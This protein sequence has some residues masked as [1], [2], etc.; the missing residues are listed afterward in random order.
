MKKFYFLKI[1][2]V[3]LAAICCFEA[4]AKWEMLYQLRSPYCMHIAP[5]G[6]MLVA[7]YLFD[8]T[9]GIYLSEDGGAT[10]TKT[11]APDYTYGKF[12]DAG[13]YVIATGGKGRIARSKD[14]G[15]TWEITNYGS[16]ISD[17]LSADVIE[18]TIC[19]AAAYHNERLYIGDFNGGGILYSEDF[20]ETWVRTNLESLQYEADGGGKGDKP[21]KPTKLT[22]NIYNLVSYK[23]ELYAFGVYFVFKY[24]EANDLWITLRND[25]NFMSNSTIHNDLLVCGRSVANQSTDIEFL[26]SF[27]GTQWGEIERPTDWS[28]NNVRCLDSDGER[29]Y[30][31]FQ[32]KGFLYTG[33]NG[34]SWVSMSDGLPGVSADYP[35]LIQ[36]II[37]LEYDKDYV[38]AV[39]YDTPFSDRAIDGIYRLA[40]SELEEAS[41]IDISTDEI[42]VYC[43]G[44][45]LYVG[46]CSSVVIS[47]L[48]GRTLPAI[49]VDGKVDLQSLTPGT[50][51]YN[52]SYDC[53]TSAGKFIKK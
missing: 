3:I 8:E 12:I 44:E 33:D 5:N 19:Y 21:G 39:I 15:K 47:D 34:K 2:L 29:L 24:D 9:G 36:H 23:G 7:D 6:N 1:A 32:E 11:N 40:K 18:Y 45:F 41:H 22:E 28:D 16:A 4:N 20:G 43:D 53:K 10:W 49:V 14:N 42:N 37:D 27:D 51:I 46:E 48:S 13:D 26:V 30:I 35:D 31:G 25:S 38:Y 50:Y 52:V 17:I